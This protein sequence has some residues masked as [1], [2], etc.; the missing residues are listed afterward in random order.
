[1]VIDEIVLHNFGVYKERQT[2]SLAPPS[3]EKPI[4]L[5]GGQNGGGKTTLLDALQLVL[6]GK[7]A[8]CSNRNNLSYDE[9][10]L[11]CIN[12][13]VNPKE[14]AAIELQFRHYSRGEEHS[15]R[16]KRSWT[17]NGKGIRE[18][19]EVL[20]DARY[21]RLLTERWHDYVEEYI[22]S[23][24]FHLFFFDG[25]KIEGFADLEKASQLI[26]IAIRALLG[27]DIV[28]QL[29]ND[30]T[31][32]E[33]KK[34]T[35]LKSSTEKDHIEKLQAEYEE[36]ENKYDM[37]FQ[38]RA[39]RQGI[40]EQNNRI[41]TELQDRFRK[42]GGE[43][44]LNREKIEEKR[45]ETL[46]C[47][48]EV[49]AELREVVN[50]PLPMHLCRDLLQSVEIQ[51]K[52]ESIAFQ[53]KILNEVLEDRD[54]KIISI[55]ERSASREI[56]EA[57][58][59]FLSKDRS[60]RVKHREKVSY[61]FISEDGRMKVNNL[62]SHLIP[63][64]RKQALELIDETERLMT[65]LTEYDRIL[66][67]VPDQDRLAGL[68]R[69]TQDLQGKIEQIRA[70]IRILSEE[71]DRIGREKEQKK[72]RL[73]SEIEKTVDK[74]FEHEDTTRIINHSA[75]IRDILTVFRSEM[76]ASHVNRIGQLIISSFRQL[77][78]KKS[79]V[80]DLSIDPQDFT[81]R[82]QGWDGKVISV[83]RLSAGERQLLA[84]SILWGLARSS[85]RPLPVAI[86]TPLSRL[87]STHRTHIVER[88]FPSASHQVFLFS[89]DEEI[90]K[91]YYAKLEQYI[92]K[93]YF[94][95]YDDATRT[96]KIRPGYFEHGV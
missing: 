58:K 43:L 24:I 70:E 77:I 52:N 96:T 55:A 66:A 38:D 71:L 79:L 1:M 8:H 56:I 64:A 87:D 51:D 54:R 65:L 15:Y 82:L 10:L 85:G 41:L 63:A 39:G 86:D 90:N 74:R 37:L 47:L 89:T 93:T 53:A 21:D 94:L 83:E 2:V 57:M 26:S 42:E 61:L 68:I 18:Y 73:V 46:K 33:R 75:Q 60:D 40:L 81:I 50:G 19:V 5:F 12:N 28:D 45:L 78:R 34:K 35:S 92:G 59:D 23:R 31:F 95:D 88:Y 72:T 22:P 67:S 32:L 7:L 48:W 4:V 62:Q 69:E 29:A 20:K 76:I 84:V 9:Y 80:K 30:L 6:Y 49:E 27:L 13:S 16:V 36:V 14:G 91:K 3:P 11:R 25:E 44:F 17:Q